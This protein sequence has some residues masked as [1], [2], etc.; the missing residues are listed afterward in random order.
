[1]HVWWHIR[2][3]NFSGHSSN[4]RGFLEL[5]RKVSWRL[6]TFHGEIHRDLHPNDH[7]AASTSAIFVFIQRQIFDIFDPPLFLELPTQ[8]NWFV[9]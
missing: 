3:H 9:A 6:D 1:M 4:R 8:N 2:P 5:F 7:F